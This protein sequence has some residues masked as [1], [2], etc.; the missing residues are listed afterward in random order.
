MPQPG[1]PHILWSILWISRDMLQQVNDSQ[2]KFVLDE[3]Q[4]IIMLLFVNSAAFRSATVK[5]R[6]RAT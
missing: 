2:E 1:Y 3:N 6:R 4:G 5:C